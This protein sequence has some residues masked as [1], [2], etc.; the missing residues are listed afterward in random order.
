VRAIALN[1]FL[2][3]GSIPFIMR[4]IKVEWAMGM[5]RAC[6]ALKGC[7]RQRD[8][9]SRRKTDRDR[10]RDRQTDRHTSQPLKNAVASARP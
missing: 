3:F 10:D 7:L 6:A 2:D 1:G 4:V 5:A 8:V 9:I